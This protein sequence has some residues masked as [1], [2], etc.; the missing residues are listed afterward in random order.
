MNLKFL[1]FSAAFGYDALND[2]GKLNAPGD[3]PNILNMGEAS[4]ERMTVDLKLPDGAITGGPV[5]LS[6]KGSDTEGGAYTAIVT[7]SAVGAD[8]LSKGG[9][10]LPVPE[11]KFKYLKASLAGAFAGTV[12]AIVNS[13]LGK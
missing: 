11:T 1:L 8:G 5:T 9:Y 7:G 2:F 6:V 4:A 12:Q 13:Y 3:F 10:A